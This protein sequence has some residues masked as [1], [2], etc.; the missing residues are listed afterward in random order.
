MGRLAAPALGRSD[1]GPLWVYRIPALLLGGT[2]VLLVLLFGQDL[3]WPGLDAI[4]V[5]N[6]GE[7]PMLVD[8]RW[9]GGPAGV[10]GPFARSVD[11]GSALVLRPGGRGDL[12]IRVIEP[13]SGRVRGGLVRAGERSA[14]PR[15]LLLPHRARPPAPELDGLC[16][17]HLERDRVRIAVGR[18]LEPGTPPRERRERVFRR[19]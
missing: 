13:G 3:H 12:C 6:G 16:P 10:V 19:F 4:E 5:V 8:A 11:P 7:E 18:Y 17:Y 15:V 9:W 2:A 1:A 14:T